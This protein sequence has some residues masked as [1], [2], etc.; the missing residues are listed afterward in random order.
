MGRSDRK[1]LRGDI[2]LVLQT[3]LSQLSSLREE[4]DRAARL[5]R[6]AAEAKQNLKAD[7]EAGFRCALFPPRDGPRV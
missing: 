2:T 3:A 6:E 1:H 7:A 4:A 5:A